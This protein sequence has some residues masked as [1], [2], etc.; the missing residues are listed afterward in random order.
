MNFAQMGDLRNAY[1]TLSENMKRKE[2]S[3]D[4]NKMGG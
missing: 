1:K 2:H 3:E 4:L